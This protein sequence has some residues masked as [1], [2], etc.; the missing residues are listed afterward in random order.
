M[1]HPS[2]SVGTRLSRE[3]LDFD[4]MHFARNTLSIIFR[5]TTDILLV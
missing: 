2:L 5:S 4:A 3:R 1:F